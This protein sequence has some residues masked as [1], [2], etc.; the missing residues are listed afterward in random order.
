MAMVSKTPSLEEVFPGYE[1][2]RKEGVSEVLQEALMMLV[3]PGAA[4]LKMIKK[5]PFAPAGRLEELNKLAGIKRSIPSSLRRFLVDE[6]SAES[7]SNLVDMKRIKMNV[8]PATGVVEEFYRPAVRLK[9][10]K[11]LWHPKARIHADTITLNLEGKKGFAYNSIAGSG[12]IGPDG[13][14]YESDFVGDAVEE[15]WERG[16]KD[17]SGSWRP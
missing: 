12:G 13:S 7:L 14:Y 8:A 10:G 11:I 4:G 15:L 17:I 6:E 9:G 3:A 1:Q 5:L 2:R 16:I